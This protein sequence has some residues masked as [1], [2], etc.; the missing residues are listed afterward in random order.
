MYMYI[1]YIYIHIIIIIIII[2]T[3]TGFALLCVCASGET[4]EAKGL[5]SA[6]LCLSIRLF[7]ELDF[8]SLCSIC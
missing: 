6:E 5:R 8:Q 1:Y 3:I 7:A 4:K 2:I